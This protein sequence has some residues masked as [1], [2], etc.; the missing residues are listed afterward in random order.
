MQVNCANILAF[1]LFL[2]FGGRVKLCT[3]YM[4]A[5]LQNASICACGFCLILGVE[6]VDSRVEPSS[7]S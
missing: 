5:I 6:I 4:A 7:R 3:L 1:T 2:P